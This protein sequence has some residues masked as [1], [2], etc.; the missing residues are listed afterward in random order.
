LSECR[1]LASD[2][3]LNFTLP[4]DIA[5]YSSVFTSIADKTHQQNDQI[6]T[7]LHAWEF[8]TT[9]LTNFYVISYTLIGHKTK[10][11]QPRPGV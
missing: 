8:F 11:P 3:F 7:K 1:F 4:P 9:T 10:N 2:A 6:L 5:S